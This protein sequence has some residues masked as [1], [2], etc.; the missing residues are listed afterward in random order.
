MKSVSTK[1][2][3]ALSTV[4]A[5]GLGGS[6][7]FADMSMINVSGKTELDYKS[8]SSNDYETNLSADIEL[9]MEILLKEGIRAVV[10]TE[11]KRSL[12]ENGNESVTQSFDWEKF[13]K[14]AYIEIE[15]DKTLGFAKAVVVGKHKVA[16]SQAISKMA[17]PQDNLLYN[18]QNEQEVIGLTVAIPQST[19]NIVDEAAI[20]VF[21]AGK[22]D[23]RV[24]R[25]KGISGKVTK[26]LTKQLKSTV[27]AMLKEL[28]SS[29]WEKRAALGF[30]YADEKGNWTVW[31]EGIVLDQNPIY[32]DARFGG[33]VG[34]SMK[35]G[36]GLVVVEYSYV[37]KYAH[38]LGASYH[39]PVGGNLTLA[40][41]VRIKQRLDG[42]KERTTR[43]GTRLTAAF[44]PR[45][46]SLLEE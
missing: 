2:L 46:K 38:E 9:N 16:F 18:L 30:V 39:I 41:E 45:Y 15:T 35:A 43:I 10:L 6:F 24:A 42:S 40:P 26:K 4:A 11:L 27:S 32:A 17:I 20:S 31:M 3:L 37:N 34:G 29:D 1:K 44:G 33:N 14:E 8:S 36:P 12:I 13:V 19:L 7:T 25:E 21:E 23:L 28:P 22:G 5:F